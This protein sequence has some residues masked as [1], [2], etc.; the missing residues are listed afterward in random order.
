MIVRRG[1]GVG[2]GVG[3]AMQQIG[4]RVW[5]T[6]GGATLAGKYAFSCQVG[7]CEQVIVFTP[8]R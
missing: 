1:D 7:R 2:V 3:N 4:G 8:R 5:K 6:I